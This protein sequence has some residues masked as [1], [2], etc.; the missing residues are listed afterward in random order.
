MNLIYAIGLL[1]LS[2]LG[3]FSLLNDWSEKSSY[4]KRWS[5][6][7]TD[8][9]S[10]LLLWFSIGIGFIG[11][12]TTWFIERKNRR[13][14]FDLYELEM[15]LAQLEGLVTVALVQKDVKSTLPS[16]KM[17]V[18]KIGEYGFKAARLLKKLEDSLPYDEYRVIRRGAMAITV[19]LNYFEVNPNAHFS[20]EGVKALVNI[21]SGIREAR[22]GIK[23]QIY[24]R[25]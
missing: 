11:G 22:R 16:I 13:I 21:Q 15:L 20:D 17:I 5:A 7:E 19:G 14:I 12:T 10:F 25:S 4:P 8:R 6:L 23:V 24:D 3:V 1:F 2:T 9:R 18:S